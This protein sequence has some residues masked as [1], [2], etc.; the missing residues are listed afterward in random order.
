[1]LG[2]RRFSAGDAEAVITVINSD[3]LP[4]QPA[5]SESMLSEAVAGR[6][7]VDSGWWAELQPPVTEVLC[8]ADGVICGVVSYARRPR[9][10][11]GLVLWVH[12]REERHVV[13]GL[14]DRAIDELDGARSL[15]AFEFAC[16]LSVGLEG[17][18]SRHR[19]V[20]RSALMARGFVEADLWRYMHRLLPAPEV[21]VAAEAH[22]APDSEQPGWVIELLASG[23]TRVADA[24]V[25]VAAPGL[26][27]LWWIGVDPA[28][29]RQ[30]L[31][32]RLL[33]TALDVLCRAGAREAILFVDDDAAPDD[34]ERGRGAANALY[35]R[36]GFTEVD[37]LCSYRRP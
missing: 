2:V 27:V 5:C 26:G 3:R 23:G 34:P 7:P 6:S 1:M 33:G 10:N 29:R 18:P 24:H 9:D 19:P 4:G 8:D 14:L 16:A 32:W 25:S 28:H 20:T 12:G 31:G 22:I 36:A 15:E 30:Q 13:E 37:R 11:A 21:P 17:L 35:D